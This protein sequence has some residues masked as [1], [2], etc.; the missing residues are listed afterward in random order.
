MHIIEFGRGK[1]RKKR[2]RR[3]KLLRN[4]AKVAAGAG[5]GAGAAVLA[6]RGI[7]KRNVKSAQALTNE[8]KND[9]YVKSKKAAVD[10]MRTLSN[11]GN[12]SPGAMNTAR[13]IGRKVVDRSKNQLR[14]EYKKID[15]AP[16]RLGKK[17]LRTA[18][19]T[20]AIGGAGIGLM[21]T[22]VEGKNKKKKKK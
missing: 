19:T 6:T 22:S 13:E 11:I 5:L 8:L 16:A 10:S 15:A 7:R 20:G 18:A 17:Q 12:K 4:A 2:K 14:K 21:A 1:D 9:A 3:K